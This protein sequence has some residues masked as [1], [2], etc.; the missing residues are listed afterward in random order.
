MRKFSAKTCIK[1]CA[2]NVQET[3][4]MCKFIIFAQHIHFSR[5]NLNPKTCWLQIRVSIFNV[6]KRKI[7]LGF[8]LFFNLIKSFSALVSPVSL[9]LIATQREKF[10]GIIFTSL[11][12]NHQKRE[13][14]FYKNKMIIRS[15]HAAVFIYYCVKSA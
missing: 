7:F 3:N 8:I 10:Q 1:I 4:S 2:S 11:P 6:F 5:F 13:F 14:P 15:L 9:N 12:N